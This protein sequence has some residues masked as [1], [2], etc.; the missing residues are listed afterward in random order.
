MDIG[1]ENLY[2][3]T[4]ARSVEETSGRRG[5]RKSPSS[6]TC[7]GFTIN[8]HFARCTFRG[9]IQGILWQITS[10]RDNHMFS[11]CERRLSSLAR[12]IRTAM[13]AEVIIGG[14]PKIITI[15]NIPGI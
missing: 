15:F 12:E 4:G 5:S 3:D 2:V 13:R 6:A 8:M 1:M 10:H 7:E 11:I 14:H 9:R